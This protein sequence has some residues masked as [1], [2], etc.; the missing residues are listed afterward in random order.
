MLRNQIKLFIGEEN[1]TSDLLKELPG[2]HD[3][4]N[5]KSLSYKKTSG[6]GKLL[7]GESS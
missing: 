2:I 5:K 4:K 3:L 7:N 6:Y 1:S